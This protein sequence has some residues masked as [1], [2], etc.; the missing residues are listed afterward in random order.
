MSLLPTGVMETPTNAYFVKSDLS[1]DNVQQTPPNQVPIVINPGGGIGTRTLGTVNLKPGNYQITMPFTI[2]LPFGN[3]SADLFYI[4]VKTTETPA[5]YLASST[6]PP[7]SV[8]TGTGW[9]GSVTYTD[10]L[11]GPLTIVG[12][13]TQY[14]GGSTNTYNIYFNEITFQYIG[15]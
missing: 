6:V 3:V 4:A 13:A 14:N 7:N 10:R 15:P 12:T 8:Y 2:V 5:N 11:S 1:N 9:Y